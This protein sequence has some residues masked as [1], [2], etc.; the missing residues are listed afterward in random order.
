MSDTATDLL[1]KAKERISDPAHWTI[2][3]MARN[4]NGAAVSP[5]SVE[6]TCFCAFGALQAVTYKVH[7]GP[8]L[9]AQ[10]SLNRAARAMGFFNIAALND[11]AYQPAD[12]VTDSTGDLT[13]HTKLM[14]AFD[15]A[16]AGDY[17]P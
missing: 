3:V 1:R 4:K 12:K 17:T 7:S 10:A 13:V 15:K 11:S 6:A 2:G 14:K 5:R 8:H 16:I 9:S